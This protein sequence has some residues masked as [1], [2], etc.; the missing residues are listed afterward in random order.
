MLNNL[1]TEVDN[2]EDS[3]G[4][5]FNVIEEVGEDGRRAGITNSLL[6]SLADVNV[7]KGG[8]VK[9][10]LNDPFKGFGVDLDGELLELFGQVDDH[11]E[12]ELPGGTQVE[13]VLLVLH[14]DQGVVLLHLL[15]FDQLQD[16]LQL[17]VEVVFRLVFA[18]YALVAHVLV[19]ILNEF[20]GV[21]ICYKLRTLDALK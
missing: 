18:Y 10:G 7:V 6:N 8:E 21:L 15:V 12:G 14:L 16:V 2:I 3:L 13:Q 4:D 9:V 5:A 11:V 19:L 17:L 1:F 20:L